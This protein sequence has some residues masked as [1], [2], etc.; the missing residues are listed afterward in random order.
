MSERTFRVDIPYSFVL[1][2]IGEQINTK[3]GE[4]FTEE[5][6]NRKLINVVKSA[7]LNNLDELTNDDSVI[8]EVLNGLDRKWHNSEDGEVEVQLEEEGYEFISVEKL[9]EAGYKYHP[10]TCQWKDSKGRL[11]YNKN[12]DKPE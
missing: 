7:I 3:N 10:G 6:I 9:L 11:P 12:L 8:E 2:V 1:N 5:H 4:I